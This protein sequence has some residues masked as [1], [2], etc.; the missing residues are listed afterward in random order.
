MM[1][2]YFEFVNYPL[3]SDLSEKSQ[4]W[5]EVTTRSS[6]SVNGSPCYIALSQSRGKR[7]RVTAYNNNYSIELNNYSASG[8]I[9]SRYGFIVNSMSGDTAGFYIRWNDNAQDEGTITY[10]ENGSAKSFPAIS[11]Q[12][13]DDM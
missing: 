2:R 13:C 8:G 9:T 10:Y 11:V 3:N 1:S 6:I 12:V 5:I 7:L 4:K